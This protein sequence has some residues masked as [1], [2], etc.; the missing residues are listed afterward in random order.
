[1]QQQQPK[2]SKIRLA[3]PSASITSEDDSYTK[4]ENPGDS[5]Y[6]RTTQQLHDKSMVSSKAD[7]RKLH[8]SKETSQYIAAESIVGSDG[9]G[10]A[11]S[12]LANVNLAQNPLEP[13]IQGVRITDR[14]GNVTAQ[15][16]AGKIGKQH[17]GGRQSKK[18]KQLLALNGKS[19]IVNGPSVPSRVKLVKSPM[20]RN[21]RVVVS[22]EF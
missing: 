12:T 4:T 19:A 22:P 15:R 1:M 5:E 3:L 2:S 8:N 18:T 16:Q 17:L 7:N 6:D 14:A 13:H 20:T 9:V 10:Q 21:S 11:S